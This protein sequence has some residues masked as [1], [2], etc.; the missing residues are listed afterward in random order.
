MSII[1]I[2]TFFIGW[3]YAISTYGFFLGVGL[4]WFP[5]FFIALILDFII[6]RILLFLGISVYLI[7]KFK[8]SG[9]NNG[10]PIAFSKTPPSS[11][12][13]PRLASNPKSSSPA[14]SNG[15][16]ASDVIFTVTTIFV[17]ICLIV[18]AYLA[19]NT[20]ENDVGDL[21]DNGAENAQEAYGSAAAEAAEQAA[22]RAEKYTAVTD[23]PSSETEQYENPISPMHPQDQQFIV[24][25]YGSKDLYN[26]KIA[27]NVDQV[28]D[29]KDTSKMRRI[30]ESFDRT[31]EN[32]GRI[33]YIRA[34]AEELAKSGNC[35][36]ARQFSIDH[37]NLQIH[38]KI[39]SYCNKKNNHI[40]QT[41][42]SKIN[43]TQ[44][45][46]VPQGIYLNS[47]N[48][49]GNGNFEC[50]FSNGFTR[51]IPLDGDCFKP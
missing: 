33:N 26:R 9:S 31:R 51:I 41:S 16:K 25:E 21:A 35:D 44:E 29:S 12:S 18:V 17:M 36:G 10:S 49:I 5:S 30:L 39:D 48:D 24:E 34:R 22:N 50:I 13:P 23:N 27:P 7:L 15:W 1:G 8:S 20:S 43:S 37:G 14:G 32:Q 3:I 47:K 19:S 45:R 46:V 2:I 42:S 6:T 40:K 38:S 28:I 4:G 11:S